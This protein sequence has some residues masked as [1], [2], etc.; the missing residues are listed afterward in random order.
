MGTRH[1]LALVV[2]A[3]FI[4]GCGRELT[5]PEQ[6][7]LAGLSLSHAAAQGAIVVDDDGADCPAAAFSSIQAAVAA[8]APGMRIVV[9]T[10]TYHEQVTVS[11]NDV[12][13][14]ALGEPGR[15][16]VD[17]HGHDYGFRVLDASGV[18]IQGF[19]VE[20]AHE[21]DIALHGATLTTVRNNV[22]T[23]AG[24]DGIQL[25]GSD[26]N[27]IEH[28]I[29]RDNL[30]ANACGVNVAGGSKRNRVRNNLLVNNEWGVQ[31]IG[32]TTVDNVISHNQ[33]LQNR[34]N[35]IRNVNL[36]SGT[37][38][39]R[40]HTLGNGFTPSLPTGATAAGIR[41]GSGTGVVV[42]DNHAFDN[43]TVDLR[44]EAGPGATFENNHCET[45]LP[46]ELCAHTGGAS[47]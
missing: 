7:E 25:L 33:S 42:R 23:A 21:A 3:A 37:V 47:R 22:T 26:D 18:T 15:V 17:A 41:I 31:I 6:R 2:I 40:N 39:E 34:G 45:S 28:N 46:P 32:G 4:T 5:N 38:I 9:C 16:V 24:H 29:V 11:Q 27:L 43:L 35:G 13:I 19:S 14:L 12:R 10:G 1:L 36:A 20:R 8:A 30:A 44:N